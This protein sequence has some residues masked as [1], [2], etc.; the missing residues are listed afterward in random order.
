MLLRF[1]EADLYRAS[2]TERIQQEWLTNAISRYPDQETALR[3]TDGLMRTHFASAWIETE[4]EAFVEAIAL[5]DL[6]DRHVV[7]AAIAGSANY[8]VTDNIKHFPAVELDRFGIEAGTADAFL[9]GTFEHYEGPALVV[10]REH[11]AGLRAA[12][13]AAKYLM[14]LRQKQMPRLASRLMPLRDYL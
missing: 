6:D 10:L 8:I 7:A 1:F 4:Y 3:R 13:S 11:R 2:W 5:P 9:A 12:P 14:M